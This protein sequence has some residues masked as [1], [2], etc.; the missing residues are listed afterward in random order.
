MSDSTRTSESAE[1]PDRVNGHSVGYRAHRYECLI[2]GTRLMNLMQFQSRECPGP[3]TIERDDRGDARCQ[4]C[5]GIIRVIRYVLGD[6]WMHVNPNAGF[7][8]QHKGTAWR[9]CH[10]TVAEPRMSTPPGTPRGAP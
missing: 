6:E 1:V 8:S 2:C 7:P 9:H 10:N 4:N 3:Q 5:N